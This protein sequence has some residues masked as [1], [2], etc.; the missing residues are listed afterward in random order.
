M[1]HAF[2]QKNVRRIL[3]AGIHGQQA[4]EHVNEKNE[5]GVTS[6]VFSPLVFMPT[7]SALEVLL[8][9]IGNRLRAALRG[10]EVVNH[11]IQFWPGGLRTTN[12]QGGRDSRCEPDVLIRLTFTEGRPLTL[13]G[14]MKWD[15]LISAEHLSDEIQR[16]RSAVRMA[17]PDAEQLVFAI[18]KLRATR[19]PEGTELR[20]WIQV[21]RNARQLERNS[22]DLVAARWGALVSTFLRKAKQA[23]FQGFHSSELETL[24]TSTPVFWTKANG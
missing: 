24:H 9:V 23:S 2:N 19:P 8:A 15:W 13:I 22:A 4:E 12:W 3:A 5:D 7:A 1:L 6:M 16:Q 20:N 11:D 21:E 17:E 14:E 18:T 10:R